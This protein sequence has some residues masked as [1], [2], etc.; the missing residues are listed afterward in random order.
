[1]M[2][3]RSRVR[4]FDVPFTQGDEKEIRVFDVFS[5]DTQL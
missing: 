1:M 2:K 4:I 5:I 3:T